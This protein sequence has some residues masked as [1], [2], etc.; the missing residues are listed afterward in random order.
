MLTVTHQGA[1]CDAASVHFG[2]TIRKTNLLLHLDKARVS[3]VS[4]SFACNPHVPECAVPAN[5]SQAPSITALRPVSILPDCL[6]RHLPGPF[7]LRYSVVVF[8][9][10]LLFFRFCAVR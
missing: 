9:F 4:Q 10:S 7:L 1:A 8:S 5:T 2:P 3:D 6:H